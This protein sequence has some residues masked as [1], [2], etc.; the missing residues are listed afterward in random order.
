MPAQAIHKCCIWRLWTFIKYQFCCAFIKNSL[1]ILRHINLRI[2]KAVD[3][4]KRCTLLICC[5]ITNL[6]DI[7]FNLKLFLSK[8]GL[9]TPF[10]Y[11]LQFMVS[12]R[13]NTWL[14]SNIDVESTDNQIMC[15]YNWI[16]YFILFVE[17]CQFDIC[18]V[19]I[20][21]IQAVSSELCFGLNTVYYLK[22]LF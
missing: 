6:N 20:N 2:P 13:S 14:S 3:F 11:N 15:A 12:Y 8:P 7:A 1:I 5:V 21:E 18:L 4:I 9:L 17:I 19:L 10:K 16:Y 22:V